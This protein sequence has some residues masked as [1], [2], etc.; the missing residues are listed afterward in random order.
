MW[1]SSAPIG[2]GMSV[3]HTDWAPVIPR[4][5]STNLYR[6]V[7][8]VLPRGAVPFASDWGDN[9]YCLM[10]SGPYAEQVVYW[11]HERDEGD[12]RVE[13]VTGSVDEFYAGLVPDP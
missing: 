1:S 2:L 11:D 6:R 7:G 4:T 9:L 8:D 10:L 5:N 12:H 13:P 3:P